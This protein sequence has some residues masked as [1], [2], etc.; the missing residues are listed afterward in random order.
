MHNAGDDLCE[1]QVVGYMNRDLSKVP[2]L[3]CD[4]LEHHGD[5]FDP[6]QPRLE[7]YIFEFCRFREVDRSRL[8]LAWEQK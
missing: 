1:G 6:P 2:M 5:P 3:G 4:G 7:T 8:R